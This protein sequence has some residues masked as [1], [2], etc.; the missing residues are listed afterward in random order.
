MTLK[1]LDFRTKDRISI[2]RYRNVVMAD[3]CFII[4]V[5][6][7]E[8]FRELVVQIPKKYHYEKE[9]NYGEFDVLKVT[10]YNVLTD[11]IKSNKFLIQEKWHLTED[12]VE[13]LLLELKLLLIN[14][15][16]TCDSLRKIILR[17]SVLYKLFIVGLKYKEIT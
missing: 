15:Y 16:S 13:E 14:N 9:L 3:A 7:D 12:K 2:N 4:L 17:F 8:K 6:E 11:Y 10:E 1:V 5:K